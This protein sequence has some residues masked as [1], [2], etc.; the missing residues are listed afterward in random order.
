MSPVPTGVPTQCPPSA[1]L[2]DH[3]EARCPRGRRPAVTPAGDP[4]GHIASAHLVP[5]LT[6][7]SD[8]AANRLDLHK[9]RSQDRLGGHGWALWAAH[10][11]MRV[12]VRRA[13]RLAVSLASARVG[14]ETPNS[15]HLCPPRNLFPLVSALRPLI[16]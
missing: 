6:I 1:H 5:T 12:H 16:V 15:A 13:P 11:Y 9:R 14:T 8:L 4:P 7:L 3:G 2:A 10:P